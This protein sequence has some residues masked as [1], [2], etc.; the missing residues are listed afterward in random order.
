MKA[1]VGLPGSLPFNG[2]AGASI[3]RGTRRFRCFPCAESSRIGIQKGIHQPVYIAF[4]LGSRYCAQVELLFK[5]YDFSIG[6][7]GELYPYL[8]RRR[9]ALPGLTNPLGH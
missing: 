4:A 8:M 6:F 3:G 1:S 2:H 7:I 9:A 5:R